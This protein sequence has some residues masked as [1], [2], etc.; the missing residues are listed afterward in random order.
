LQALT[1]LNDAAFYEFAE[2]LAHRVTSQPL[3]D[4]SDR[5]DYAFRLCV[6]RKPTDTERRRLKELLPQQLAGGAGDAKAIQAEA[7]TTVARVLLNLDE[8]I[9]RE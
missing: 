4:D 7:W 6:A 8:T 2:G 5:L 9:T 1:L 3:R